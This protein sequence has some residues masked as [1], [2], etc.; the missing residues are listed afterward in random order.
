MGFSTQVLLLA[1]VA[2]GAG[3]V[4]GARQRDAVRL[5]GVALAVAG[6][7][8]VVGVVVLGVRGT[9]GVFGLAHVLYLAV[10]VTVP[11]MSAG[12]LLFVGVTRRDLRSRALRSMLVAAVLPALVG[13]YATHVEPNRLHTDHRLVLVDHSTSLRIGVL[14]DMQTPN[15]G[16]HERNAV[17]RLID[18]HPDVVVVPGDLYQ[19]SATEFERRIAEFRLLIAELVDA[20]PHVVVVEGDADNVAGLSRILDG[21]GAM[22]LSDDVAELEVRGSAVA[23]GGLGLSSH[24]AESGRAVID[25]LAS[26][27]ADVTT[28][29]V[30][31]RPDALEEV[32]SG[33][34]DLIVA[35]HTHGGQIAVPFFGPLFT[36]SDV[37]RGVA[38]GGLH[39]VDGQTIYVSTGVGMER[40][41]APQVRLFVR[42]S[43]AVLDLR[44]ES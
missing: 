15:V 13:V 42:P 5:V 39:D 12:A 40:H 37:P 19:L 31:H 36:L 20:V 6:A 11:T 22:L 25:E 38:A 28:I 43:V 21:T 17:S 16:D 26:M 33:T 34:I 27:P 41:R 24:D 8:T 1:F 14:S 4:V 32:E 10:T 3:L 7:A 18:S 29:L 30:S 44:G 2:A 35:G 23:I 9:V